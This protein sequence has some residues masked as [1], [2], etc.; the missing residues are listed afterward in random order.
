M[1][2]NKYNFNNIPELTL[3]AENL[4]LKIEFLRET[5]G[6]GSKSWREEN[7][8]C[9]YYN[10]EVNQWNLTI[11]GRPTEIA[12]VWAGVEVEGKKTRKKFYKLNL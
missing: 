9:I 6:I 2:N 12:E 11:E 7:R 10:F 8:M 1:K 3:K 4:L 5:A